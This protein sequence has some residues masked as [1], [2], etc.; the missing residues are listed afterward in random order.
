MRAS[1]HT[2]ERDMTDQATRKHAIK[3]N[4]ATALEEDIGSGD[5]TAMLIPESHQATASV[6][7]REDAILCGTDWANAVFAGVD[8]ALDVKWLAEEGD[9]LTAGQQFLSIKGSA[10]S[11]LIAER[12]ALN[13]IQTLSSTAT[14]SA[15]YARLVAHT[16]VKLLD[17]RKTIPGLRIAQKHAVATGGCFNHRIGLYDAFLIKENHII[18]CGSIE[19]AVSQAHTIAPGKPVEIEVESLQELKQAL[20]AGADIVML[21]NFSLEMMREGV[22]LAKGKAK[23][24][25]SGNVTS[26]TLVPI[27]ETGVDYISIGVLTKDVKAIDLSMRFDA[28]PSLEK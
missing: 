22:A 3:T 26:K 19:Q 1:K 28:D 21:D 18:A 20:D 15:Q 4:V 6:I 13:F 17:T 5:I 12:C 16:D 14:T 2:F 25:A 10:R 11:V 23:L 27:A 8:S 7:T 24:E 9:A